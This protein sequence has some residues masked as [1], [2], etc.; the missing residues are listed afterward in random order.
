MHP[1]NT[2]TTSNENNRHAMPLISVIVPCY[3]VEQWAERCISSLLAQTHP[4]FEVVAVND[5]STDG[6]GSLLDRMALADER[7]RPVHLATNG[8]LHAARRAGLKEARSGLIGF[9]D[10]DDHVEPDMFFTLAEALHR[11]GTDMALCGFRIERLDGIL[12]RPF[13]YP[14]EVVLED[15]LPD[16]F[17][18]G[19]FGSGAIWNKLYKRNIIEPELDLALDRRLDSGADYI[20]GVGCFARAGKVVTVP[21]TPYNYALRPDSM[22]M[23]KK[24]APSFVFQMECYAACAEA[25]AHMEEPVLQAIDRLYA[26]QMTFYNYRVESI[27][28]L[29]PHRERLSASLLTLARVRP[30]AVYHLVHAFDRSNQPPIALPV[31][32]HLG[33]LRISIPKAIKALIK[34]RA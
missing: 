14:H 18:R 32:F 17:A 12:K 6:T 15:T 16:R 31:R 8:G 28:D 7:L 26:R 23:A 10:G 4:N 34:G 2:V 20:V 25:H 13:S 27:R 21:G 3:N 11:T 22:S 29:V 24:G 9:V 30:Q 33:Q 5:C 1:M 19:E